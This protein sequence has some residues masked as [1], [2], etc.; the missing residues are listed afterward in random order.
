MID[1][2][3]V[4]HT[5]ARALLSGGAPVFLP[6]NPVEYHGPHLSLR[7]D[8]LLTRGVIRDLHAELCARG[9]DHPLLVTSDLELGVDPARGPGSRPVPYRVARASIVRACQSLARLGAKRVVLMTF[10]GSPLHGHAIDA[11]VQ[12]LK[13]AGIPALSPMNLFLRAQLT[14]TA[15]DFPDAYAPIADAD[16]RLAVMREAPVDFHGGYLE[17]SLALHYAPDSVDPIYKS[18][19]PCPVVVPDA[20]LL[21]AA[22][23]A[24]RVGRLALAN[25]LTH[26]ALGA[27]WFALRPFPGYASRPHCAN[28]EAGRVTATR[29]LREFGAVTARVMAGEEEPPAPPMPWLLPLTLGGR[30]TI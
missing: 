12:W 25:E 7:N 13:R 19:P 22:R 17:T 3:D 8:A 4:S 20:R 2:F 9:A 6:V 15:D 11:G 23:A 14:L 29:F 30:F 10:H 24:R 5:R 16:E 1:V 18:V 27:G 28:V 26:A 21:L